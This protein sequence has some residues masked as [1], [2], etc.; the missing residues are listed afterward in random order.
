MLERLG[1][2]VR[3]LDRGALARSFPSW[4]RADVADGYFN[5]RGGWVE[6]GAAV[7]AWARR[8]V[9]AGVRLREETTVTDLWSVGGAVRGVNLASGE[10]LGAD[11]VLVTAGS[12]T[13]RLM[14]WLAERLVTRAQPVFHLLPPDPTLFQG[15]GWPPWAMDLGED[16]WY[17]L[18]ANRQG[19]VKVARHG[20]GLPLE[21]DGPGDVPDRFTVALGRFLESHLPAL[22]TARIAARRLCASTET[23]DGDFLI[24]A[25][26]EHPGLIVSTGGAAHAFKFAPLLGRITADVVDGRAD[27]W[28]ERF[29]WQRSARPSL[30]PAR[31]PV[32]TGN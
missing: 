21:P 9:G 17:G 18:P 22:A 4:S 14:P 32:P 1:R 15:R 19:V 8:A 7:A 10:R 13:V 24:D 28:R 30:G 20:E 11:R 27:P 6:A 2:P 31:T 12:D 5:P 23:A 3:H 16:G 29:A 26:P 25:D